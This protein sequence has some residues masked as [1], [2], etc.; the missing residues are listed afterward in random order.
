MDAKVALDVDVFVMEY[1]I[2]IIIVTIITL[3]V[4]QK[5]LRRITSSAQNH[6]IFIPSVRMC[7]CVCVRVYAHQRVLHPRPKATMQRSMVNVHTCT[8]E[9]LVSFPVPIWEVEKHRS[10]LPPTTIKSVCLD[11]KLSHLAFL[12]AKQNQPSRASFFP[13]PSHR[14][15][16][17]CFRCNAS[18]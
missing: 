1:P 12:L 5:N 2:S 9:A 7:V 15:P 8:K 10:I 14:H 4:L 11:G 18:A 13:V 17:M 16:E 3:S 6:S